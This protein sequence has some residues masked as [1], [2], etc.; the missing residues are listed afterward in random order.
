MTNIIKKKR[1]KQKQDFKYSRII[2]RFVKKKN[3]KEHDF[4]CEPYLKIVRDYYFNQEILLY[5][6]IYS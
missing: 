6:S 1:K 5:H 3:R 4:S 2:N